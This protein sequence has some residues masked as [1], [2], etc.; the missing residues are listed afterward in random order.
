MTRRRRLPARMLPWVAVALAALVAVLGIG[1]ARSGSPRRPHLVD[2]VGGTAVID[3]P[4][5]P[6]NLNPHTVAGDTSMT[7]AVATLLWPQ[8][9]VVGP[10]LTPQL[11]T[12]LLV[13]AE[14]V[15][16]SPETVVYHINPAARWSDGTPIRADAFTYLWHQEIQPAAGDAA[17]ASTGASSTANGGHSVDTALGY[18]DI[19][20][21]TSTNNGTTVTVV[22]RT[23]Y[24]DWPGLFDSLLP[25]NAATSAGWST[26]FDRLDQA[27]E[28]SGGPWEV[29]SWQPGK[30]LVLDHNPLW[31]GPK[32][33]LRQVVLQAVPTTS[34]MVGD[35]TSNA[36]QL[37]EPD[38]YGLST[39]NAVS[40]SPTVRSGSSLGTTMMQLD[41]NTARAPLQTAAVRQAISHLIDR[42]QLVTKLVQPLQPLAWVDDNFLFPNSQ[43]GY[44][45]DGRDYLGTNPAVAA[46]L[47]A[48]A[49]IA[50]DSQGVQEQDGVPVSLTLIWAAGDP[51]S[52]RIAP[53]IAADLQAAGFDVV[54]H[55]VT[56]TSV[57]AAIEQGVP[58]N[59][60]IVPIPGQ[61]YS[62][63]L[64]PAFSTAFGTYGADGVHDLS[65]FDSPTID[66][67]LTQAS[68]Q[69]FAVTASSDYHQADTELWTAM[70]ALPL[71][72]EPTVLA[73]SSSIAGVEGDDGGAGV[74]WNAQHLAY[75]RRPSQPSTLAAPPA[76]QRKPVSL[77]HR[78]TVALPGGR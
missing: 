44:H 8:T 4:S 42:T 6:T 37:I 2:A 75:V 53:T 71:F 17:G 13:S 14:V 33:D 5:V 61:A 72:A 9:Y 52:K 69:L 31:W 77:V 24:A 45:D 56:G 68:R 73:W 51:W 16:V 63:L 30:R 65:G 67:T 26:G 11:N 70:P 40:S 21:V 1:V 27:T 7:N 10:G 35:L 15:S 76:R 41:Y 29:A 62:S 66:T 18:R 3:V 25:P 20:S 57:S 22:F 39:L 19:A 74:L 49:G 12:D 78:R 36:A 48:G 59:L 50:P 54:S 60:A 28:V 34:A 55:P 23:P 46:Q 38:G 64:A 58:W 43:S 32:P 47:L